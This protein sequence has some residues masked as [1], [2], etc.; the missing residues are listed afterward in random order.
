MKVPHHLCPDAVDVGEM[1][2]RL[3][4]PLQA[5]GD[6]ISY[7]YGARLKQQ[8]NVSLRLGVT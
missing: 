3:K 6:T 2:G 5:H 7:C 8:K 4:G 1:G